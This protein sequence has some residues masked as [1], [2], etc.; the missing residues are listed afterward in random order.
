MIHARPQIKI[1][2]AEGTTI[3]T[4][5]RSHTPGTAATPHRLSVTPTGP[6]LTTVLTHEE[7]AERAY[8]IYVQNG[9]HEGQC[10][11]NWE[12]AEKDLRARGLLACHAEHVR[13]E[14]F[15]P[16]SIEAP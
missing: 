11:Q 13:K 15:A 10:Q 5:P 2:H 9:C 4:F 7:V 12:Q 6:I 14:V 1:H 3:P 8:D 16:D